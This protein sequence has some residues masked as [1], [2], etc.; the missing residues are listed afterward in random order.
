MNAMA[1][2]LQQAQ[3]LLVDSSF[4]VMA[5]DIRDQHPSEICAHGR[6]K[7]GVELVKA[8]GICFEDPTAFAPAER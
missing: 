5:Y 3:F 7:S 6:M 2:D 8:A 1:N 4:S